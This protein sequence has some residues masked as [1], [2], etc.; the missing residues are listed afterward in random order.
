MSWSN[1]DN[2]HKKKYDRNFVSC[3]EA[4]ERQFIIDTI[5]EE[6]PKLD[7]PAIEEAINACCKSIKA[8]RTRESFIKCIKKKFGHD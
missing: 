1:V 5:A 4:Y 6:F 8:P 2:K 7:R 3:E